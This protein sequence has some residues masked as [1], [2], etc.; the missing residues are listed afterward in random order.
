MLLSELP[1]HLERELTYPIDSSTVIEQIGTVQVEAPDSSDSETVASIL[2]PLGPESFDSAE[3]LF[4]TIF[5]SVSDDFIGRKF[6]D[7]RGGDPL[8]AYDGIGDEE[9]VSF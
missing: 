7:D 9:D 5:G 1:E 4:A 8:G 2:D 6:Y 3:D